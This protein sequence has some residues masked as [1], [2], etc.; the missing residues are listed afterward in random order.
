MLLKVNIFQKSNDEELR[1]TW[2]I[3]NLD[4]KQYI[5][6]QLTFDVSKTIIHCLLKQ[7]INKDE[8][9]LFRMD[10]FALCWYHLDLKNFFEIGLIDL[11]FRF[12]V[13][14]K[15]EYTDTFYN[16]FLQPFIE[17]LKKLIE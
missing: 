14:V 16:Q 6:S 17:L 7:K 2:S 8:D 9:F 11:N 12:N 13:Y 10:H 4:P 15:K 5:Q 3:Q 1:F